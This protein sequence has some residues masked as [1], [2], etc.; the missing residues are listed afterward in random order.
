MRKLFLDE[1]DMDCSAILEEEEE[2]DLT[3]Q[4]VGEGAILMNWIA[5]PSRARQVPGVPTGKLLGFIVSRRGIELDPSKTKAIQDLPSPNNKKDVMSFLGRLNYISH[6]IAQSTVKVAS[7]KDVTKNVVA[8]FVRDRIAAIITDNAA[9]LN[10]YLM[11]AIC[12]TFKIKHQNSTAYRPPMNGAV[13]AANKNIKKILWKMVDNYKQWH[14][15]LPFYFL[16]YRT[17]VRTSTGAT[18]YLLVYGTEVVIPAEVEIPSL[19]IV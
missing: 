15:N 18:P 7:Y 17:I 6:F 11:K 10:S 8:D 16:C 5:A 19:R 3:I 9:N 1:E 12:E 13:E 2:E 14:E 4:I